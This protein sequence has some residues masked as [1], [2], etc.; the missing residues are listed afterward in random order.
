VSGRVTKSPIAELAKIEGPSI[1]EL[2]DGRFVLLQSASNDTFSIV[3][4]TTGPTELSADDLA[5]VFPGITLVFV[6]QDT[7]AGPGAESPLRRYAE[8][9]LSGNGEWIRIVVMSIVLQLCGL[10]LPFMNGRIMDRVLPYGDKHLLIVMAVGLVSVIA[11]EFFAQLARS[12]LLLNMRARLDTKTT[13]GFLDHMLSLPY[14]FFQWQRPGDLMMR[15]HCSEAIREILTGGAL[16]AAIDGVLVIVYLVAL[17]ALSVKMTLV[18]LGLVGCEA[19]LYFA[20]R[21]RLLALTL[22]TQEKKAENTSFLIEMLNGIE[23]LKATGTEYRAAQRWGTL[24]A[25][26]EKISL[27]RGRI[28]GW[29]ESVLHVISSASPFVLLF[30]G[31]SD[32]MSDRISF[33]TLMSVLV[34]AKGFIHP[35]SSLIGLLDQ[36]QLVGVYLNRIQDVVTTAPEQLNPDLQTAP[37][38]TGAISVRNVWFQYDEGNKVVVRDVSL[39]IEPGTAIAIVG[40]SGSG[41][42]TLAALLA[43][44][45][46][47]SAGKIAYDGID[48]QQLHLPTLRRQIGV[49]LQKP[50]IFATSVRDNIAQ[51]DSMI[52]M[53]AIERAAKAACIHDEIMKMPMGYDTPLIADGKTLSGGQRQR[54]AIASAMVRKPPIMLLDEATSAL[55][56]VTE[57]AVHHKLDKLGCTKIIIAHRLSTIR[58]ADVIVVMENGE[59]VEQGSYRELLAKGGAFAKLVHAHGAPPSSVAQ[60]QASG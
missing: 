31:T 6:P 48:I 45:Y 59:L 9:A 17:L 41:K 58:R 52:P 27:R 22:A 18:S 36:F 12:N 42:S 3:D 33:G 51:G 7:F 15:L 14:S 10:A 55:D 57:R 2:Y 32:A 16:S 54:L 44:L 1:L 60:A 46:R 8:K 35:V 20:L 39:D 5:A 40:R 4:P 24:F 47:P 11:F 30:I 50:F 21:K 43:G 23:T 56:N 38:L 19:I 25:E 34:F 29:E 26:V 53:S 49:V 13:I 28:T 37:P